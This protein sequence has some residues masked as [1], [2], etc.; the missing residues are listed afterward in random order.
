MREKW[1][2][3]KWPK[4]RM[5]QK[6]LGTT[7]LKLETTW[8]MI[9]NFCRMC[10]QEVHLYRW[11][12]SL[13]V[14]IWNAVTEENTIMPAHWW[15]KSQNTSTNSTKDIKNSHAG[16][17]HVLN[18]NLCVKLLTFIFTVI[19]RVKVGLFKKSNGVGK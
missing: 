9:Q 2:V 19:Q 6:R 15:W 16:K 3:S 14:H 13:S 8:R 7:D 18:I 17:D 5:H 10:K 12:P 4:R 11:Q 1:K